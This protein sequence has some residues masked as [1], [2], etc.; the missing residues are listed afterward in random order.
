MVKRL[1]STSYSETVQSIKLIVMVV[2]NLK[3][4]KITKIAQKDTIAK[5]LLKFCFRRG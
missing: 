3:I 1:E 5:E 4:T 2:K